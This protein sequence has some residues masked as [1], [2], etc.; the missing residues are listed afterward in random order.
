MKLEHYWELAHLRSL[1]AELKWRVQQLEEDDDLQLKRH[2]EVT[3]ATWNE[4][5]HAVPWIRSWLHFPETVLIHRLRLNMTM[6]P[7]GLRFAVSIHSL[8]WV[9]NNR[10][11]NGG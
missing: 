4:L 6:S 10:P 8:Q 11:S 3:E 5:M 7:H 1:F 2:Q 9:Q